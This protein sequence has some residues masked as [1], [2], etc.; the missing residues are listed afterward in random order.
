MIGTKAESVPWKQS[1]ALRRLSGH[2]LERP[3][4]PLSWGRF[5]I[6]TNNEQNCKPLGLAG[7]I[8][9]RF[10]LLCR[11]LWSEDRPHIALALRL[12]NTVLFDYWG[13]LP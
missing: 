4:T 9:Q 8:D 12:R 13:K 1:G 11:T 7:R 5:F 2:D 6:R 10:F 3:Q